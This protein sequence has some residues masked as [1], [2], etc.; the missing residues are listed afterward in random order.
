M[1][2]F[3]KAHRKNSTPAGSRTASLPKM[4]G[5][6]QS[7]LEL[8]LV[9]PVLLIMLLGLVEVS[10]YIASYLNALDLTREAA[11]FAS[12]R[13]PFDGKTSA[14]YSVPSYATSTCQDSDPSKV[15]FYYSTAC[16]F[17]SPPPYGGSCSNPNFCGG[18]NTYLPFN[19]TTDD[20]VI[21]V[22]TVSDV[23]HDGSTTSTSV[24]TDL[25]PSGKHYW[26][27]SEDVLGK[28]AGHG[29]WTL[30]C[31]ASPQTVAN[32]PYYNQTTVGAAMLTGSVPTKGFV[33]VELYY[34]Y[35]QVLG[36]PILTNFIP[37]PLRIH[38]YTLMPNPA[39]QPT[40]T[41]VP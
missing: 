17:S 22:F 24:A 37:N 26:S 21:S 1:H 19:P 8:A 13:D 3:F 33:G 23:M 20:I 38:V 28:A 4:K 18:L 27:Y 34:C 14:G 6:G 10:F 40:D 12:V 32:Q 11:R 15:D 16:N 29:N 36:L 25:W 39:S 5:R 31:A 9:L 41:P 30:N 7:Y 35:Q 2:I